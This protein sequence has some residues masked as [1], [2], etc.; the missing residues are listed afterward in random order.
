MITL[1]MI[2][3]NPLEHFMMKKLRAKHGVFPNATHSLDAHASMALF[4]DNLHCGDMLPD[5]VFLDLEMPGFNGWDFLA[6]LE[7]LYPTLPKPLDLYVISSSIR[8]EDMSLA[9]RYEC[10]RAYFSKP[11]S[12]PQLCKL[13][14]H[15]A[16]QHA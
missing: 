4:T 3:D 14:A 7:P 1:L 12:V 13:W 16:P 9:E 10:V 5:V 6:E 2:D 11:I 15:Y 8:S